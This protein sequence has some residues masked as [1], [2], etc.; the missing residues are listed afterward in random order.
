MADVCSCTDALTDLQRLIHSAQ[1]RVDGADIVVML[2]L[3]QQTIAAAFADESDFSGLCRAN[4]CAL[5]GREIDTTMHP[6][7]PMNRV[8]S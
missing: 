2:Y 4:N 8:L 5:V 1:V 3:D 7:I 6:Y